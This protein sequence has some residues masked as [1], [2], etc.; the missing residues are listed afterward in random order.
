MNKRDN[1][2]C[3]HKAHILAAET[4]ND[5]VNIQRWVVISP[6]R[7]GTER[8]VSSGWGARSSQ[9]EW[10]TEWVVSVLRTETSVLE[11]YTMCEECD[12]S[13]G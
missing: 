10:E 9:P 1:H 12:R 6:V 3:P 8:W 4:D 5:P 7:K 2:S 11:G 13:R